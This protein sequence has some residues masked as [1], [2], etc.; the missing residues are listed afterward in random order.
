MTAPVSKQHELLSELLRL[1]K[2]SATLLQQYDD[3][4]KRIAVL[5]TEIQGTVP[6]LPT[7]LPEHH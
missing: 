1:K 3:I 2:A 7:G 5:E 6:H 4:T